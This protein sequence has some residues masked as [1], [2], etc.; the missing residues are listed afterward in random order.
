MFSVFTAEICVTN[1]S[2]RDM[3][4][5]V[6]LPPSQRIPLTIRDSEEFAYM[7]PDAKS[8]DKR[9]ACSAVELHDSSDSDDLEYSNSG[10][11]D[12]ENGR[13][14]TP[15]IGGATVLKMSGTDASLLCLEASLYLG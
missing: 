10:F 15:D 12:V 6:M 4:L 14:M 2:S 13:D 3:E 1:R 11:S 5:V 7:F 8:V 9:N